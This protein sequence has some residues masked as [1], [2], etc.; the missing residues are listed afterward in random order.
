MTPASTFYRSLCSLPPQGISLALAGL[1]A[2]GTVLPWVNVFGVTQWGLARP[3]GPFLLAL[4]GLEAGFAWE[5]WRRRRPAFWPSLA[6]G[7]AGTGIAAMELEQTWQK[8]QAVADAF[9]TF[10]EAQEGPPELAVAGW[11]FL[12]SGLYLSALGQVGL[13][14]VGLV[15]VRG[16]LLQPFRLL[17]YPLTWAQHVWHRLK[18]LV[19]P[20]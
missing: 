6:F 5:R 8:A 17:H 11:N 4:A 19:H 10:L 1:T 3:G 9:N 18:I 14:A 16:L 13:A 20:S 12:G 7:A 2:L 15:G